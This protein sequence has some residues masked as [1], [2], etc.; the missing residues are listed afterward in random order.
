MGS[1]IVRIGGWIGFD[2]QRPG[3]LAPLSFP[4]YGGKIQAIRFAGSR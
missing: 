1:W 2:P 3:H 4:A